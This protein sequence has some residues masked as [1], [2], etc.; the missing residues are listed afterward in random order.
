MPEIIR[1]IY[2]AVLEGHLDLAVEKTSA[3]IKDGIEASTIL[4]EGLIQAMQEV[5]DLFERGEFYVPEML[6]AD[7]AMQGSME[8][9]KP[10]L[11]SADI[12]PRGTLVIGA[13]QGDLHDIGKNL[14]A[15]MT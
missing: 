14:V 4:Q 10:H 3:A 8:L 1:E 13:V 5:G 6:I 12:K 9:L 11:I 2:N 15:M 7:R